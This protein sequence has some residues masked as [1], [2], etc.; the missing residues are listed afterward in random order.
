LESRG[1]NFFHMG[2]RSWSPGMSQ[3][4]QAAK[5]RGIYHVSSG[6]PGQ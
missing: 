6:L 4:L 3:A 1:E 2:E 5:A